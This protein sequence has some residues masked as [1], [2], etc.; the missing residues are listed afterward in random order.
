MTSG[1]GLAPPLAADLNGALQSPDFCIA[2][3]TW[4]HSNSLAYLMVWNLALW[5]D[6]PIPGRLQLGGLDGNHTWRMTSK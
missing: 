4:T 5:R 1:P 3:S 6:R 2:V